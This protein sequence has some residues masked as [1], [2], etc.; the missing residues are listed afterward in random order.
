MKN[1]LLYHMIIDISIASGLLLLDE[2]RRKRK[3]IKKLNQKLDETNSSIQGI[4]LNVELMEQS[5]KGLNNS[6]KNFCTKEI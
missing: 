2:L 6:L 3:E 4:E 1:K 5:Y